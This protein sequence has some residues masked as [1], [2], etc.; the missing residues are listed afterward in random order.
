MPFDS[1]DAAFAAL[2]TF[3][4]GG[5]PT[6]LS[7]IESR[8]REAAADV[9]LAGELEPRLAGLLASSAPL[10]AKAFACRQLRLIGTARSVPTLAGLLADPDLSHLGRFALERIDGPEAGE[11]LREA[12]PR[13]G[14]ELAIGMISSLASRRDEAAVPL[15][16]SLLN[17]PEPLAVAAV[18]A[19]G[20]IGTPAAAR[21]LAAAS[22]AS[23][24]F[25]DA[26]AV[27]RI[28]SADQLLAAGDRVAATALFEAVAET[29]GA[30]AVTRRSRGLRIAA[31][32]GL[33][34]CLDDA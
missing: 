21:L 30:A 33:L 15:L 11:A 6:P 12:V 5:D 25:T 8:V 16:A 9:T 29:A 4:W 28:A 22:P 13:V 7:D 3:D 23:G 24:R 27:A 20:R 14:D 34:D 2:A 18:L 26:L 19:L 10:A 1:L 31:Q 17:G 32:S